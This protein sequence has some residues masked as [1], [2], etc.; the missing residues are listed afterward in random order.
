MKNQ[1]CL[2][3]SN[4]SSSYFYFFFLFQHVR[5]N[6]KKFSFCWIQNQ[7]LVEVRRYSRGA[8]IQ[9][10]PNPRKPTMYISRSTRIMPGSLSER[11]IFISGVEFYRLGVMEL[12]LKLLME[13][14]RGQIGIRYWGTYLWELFLVDPAMDWPSPLHMLRGKFLSCIREKNQTNWVQNEVDD[15]FANIT[16]KRLLS[17]VV[18]NESSKCRNRF[19]VFIYS[20]N[21]IMHYSRGTWLYH[22]I[23]K[24]KMIAFR[25][26]KRNYR[27]NIK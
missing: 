10:S 5:V 22:Q 26:K 2:L 24:N 18:S 7:D 8:F 27:G 1:S 14:W 13:F 21:W 9:F 16:P 23:H 11:E 19:N 25:S 17:I 3:I 4:I 15:Y 20:K 6:G 12:S